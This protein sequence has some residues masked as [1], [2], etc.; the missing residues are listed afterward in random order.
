MVAKLFLAE[1]Q[2]LDFTPLADLEGVAAKKLC[3]TDGRKL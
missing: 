2:L 3:Y 1:P